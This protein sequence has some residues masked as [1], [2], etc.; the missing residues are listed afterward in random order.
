[1]HDSRLVLEEPHMVW[2]EII[3]S[4]VKVYFFLFIIKN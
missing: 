4:E 1:M 2:K 3:T